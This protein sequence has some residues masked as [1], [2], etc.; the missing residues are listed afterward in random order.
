MQRTGYAN[1]S[2]SHFQGTDIWSTADPVNSSGL[3]WVG[4]YLDSLPSPVD[5][6][7]G[8]N[9]T[10]ESAARPAWPRTRQFRRSRIRPA[11]RFRARTPA[12]KRR[13]SAAPRSGSRR[14]CRSIGRSSRSCT[15]ARRRRWPRSTA[16][17]PLR[18]T[19]RRSPTRRAASVRRYAPSRG[20]GQRDRHAGVLRDHRRLRHALRAERQRDQ[21][22]VLQPDGDAQRRAARVLQRPQEPGSARRHAAGQF[23]GVRPAHLRERQPGDRSRIGVRDDRHGR[24]E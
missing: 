3:G 14:T 1:Q 15:A 17:R 2:R 18:R 8:W 19:R 11:I 13:P 12:P 21:R 9:T 24:D 20:D 7:V 6:L 10:G 23:L 16:S 5:P 4:R 22:R